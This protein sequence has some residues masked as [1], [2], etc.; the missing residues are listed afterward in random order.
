MTEEHPKD[1]AECKSSTHMEHLCYLVSQGFHLN[2]NEEYNALIT[3][4]R[5]KCERCGRAANNE[6][7]LCKP[8]KI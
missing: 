4:P 7:N 3:E 5:F 8:V 2:D 6:K 1:N